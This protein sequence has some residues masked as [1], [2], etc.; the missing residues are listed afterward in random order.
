M[1]CLTTHKWTRLNRQ[2]EASWP[3]NVFG[4]NMDE[5]GLPINP[6]KERGTAPDD[7]ADRARLKD[8]RASIGQRPQR[9]PTVY[10][11]Q[12]KGDNPLGTRTRAQSSWGNCGCYQGYACSST[13]SMSNQP[14]MIEDRSYGQCPFTYGNRQPSIVTAR[15]RGPE[16]ASQ[17]FFMWPHCTYS[18]AQKRC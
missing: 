7:E 13:L 18:A 8:V 14:R 4:E 1:F 5:R 6:G 3:T 10:T 9:G 2:Q 11:V 12:T 15:M 17:Q 16:P